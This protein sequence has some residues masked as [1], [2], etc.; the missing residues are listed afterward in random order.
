MKEMLVTIK[1]ETNPTE[2]PEGF[3][4]APFDLMVRQKLE[5]G[6]KANIEGINLSLKKDKKEF[7][8]VLDIKIK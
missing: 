2:V 7:P 1:I 5:T 3:D 4:P 8:K 6:I